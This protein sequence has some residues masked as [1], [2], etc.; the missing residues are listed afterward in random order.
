VRQLDRQVESAGR[1]PTPDPAAGHSSESLEKERSRAPSTPAALDSSVTS[2]SLGSELKER[3]IAAKQRLRDSNKAVE[4]A[5]VAYARGMHTQVSADELAYLTRE[6]EAKEHEQAQ[7]S[8]AIAPLAQE[9][10][11]QGLDESMIRL[12]ESGTRR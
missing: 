1:N 8:A 4:G 7:A 3:M 12:Y 5:E 2:P 6:L 10:R 11:E 9:A